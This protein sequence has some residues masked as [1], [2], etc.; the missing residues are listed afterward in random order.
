M[1]QNVCCDCRTLI[2]QLQDD[3]LSLVVTSPPYVN[4][5]ED[6]YD[7]IPEEIYAPFIADIAKALLPKLKEDGS[8]I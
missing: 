5:R 7:S 3:S 6:D 1:G 8:L 4:Q 2:P